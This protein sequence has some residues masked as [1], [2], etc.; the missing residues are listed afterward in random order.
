[1]SPLD[2]WSPTDGTI[3]GN[4]VADASS[5]TLDAAP[6]WIEELRGYQRELAEPGLRGDN[7]IICAPTGCGK[8]RIAAYIIH[9]HLKYRG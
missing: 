1:M 2:V 3:S 7:Y 8:T 4:L 5:L 6:G 9:E